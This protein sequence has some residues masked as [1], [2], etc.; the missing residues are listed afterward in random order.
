KQNESGNWQG[1]NDPPAITALVL[2]A[3]VHEKKYNTKTDF[4][5]K[6]FEAMLKDQRMDG[7]I[8]RDLL[9]TYNTSIA[10]ATMADANDPTLKPRMDAAVE[11]LKDLQWTPET[12]PEFEGEN[13]QNKGQQVVKGEDDPFFGGW[14]YGG[15]SRGA[16][17][18][19]LSNAHMALEA[20]RKAGVDESDP[21]IQRAIDFLTRVQNFDPTND[22][23][24][25]G[26]DG[27]FVYG[28][29]DDRNGES[30]AGEYKDENGKR[31]LRSYGSMTY[32]GLK[33]FIY[34]GLT[35][36]D[37]RVQAAYGWITSN[38]TLDENP[39]LATNDPE[40]K[41]NG[42]YYYLH[43][44]GRTM[45]L[46]DEPIVATKSG[47]ID[48][49]VALIE[50]ASTLQHEDGSFVGVKKWQE[51]NPILVTAFVVLALQE[52]REDLGEH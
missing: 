46:F 14:G 25:A 32:A 31:M 51:D 29:A 8:Y 10:L 42:Y 48:W 16:G 43:T 36:E 52:A 26:T 34:A 33:S 35:K 15:R 49:R 23:S 17:R 30:M 5:A 22:Q 19:D 28:P 9:A 20:L 4:I 47:P 18:P 3:F 44:L 24:W 1:E 27:G 50:K 13:E 6:G 40:M 38:W 41:M 11:Y 7:G 37:P 12:K 45:N 21:A 2:R 39:G